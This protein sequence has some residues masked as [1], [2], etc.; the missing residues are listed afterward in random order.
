MLDEL[1]SY[2]FCPAMS[3]EDLLKSQHCVQ[4]VTLA[5]TSQVFLEALGQAGRVR[6]IDPVGSQAEGPSTRHF[7]LFRDTVQTK[8]LMT[9][10]ICMAHQRVGVG[11]NPPP[12]LRMVLLSR[13]D[14]TSVLPRW[15]FPAGLSG[16]VKWV[17][18]SC[19]Y[20]QRPFS[21]YF[22]SGKVTSIFS[23]YLFISAKWAF[24]FQFWS[25]VSLSFSHQN[26]WGCIP[27]GM[28]EDSFL[29]I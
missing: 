9:P 27:W 16:P 14:P 15:L 18:L 11:V 22:L 1:Q 21:D 10:W 23:A 28:T 26:T 20:S 4:A 13:S 24:H 19:S 25:E 12:C 3:P 2:P 29:K 8:L 7:L 6:D 5:L 17:L